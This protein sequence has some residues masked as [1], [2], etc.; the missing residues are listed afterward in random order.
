[1]GSDTPVMFAYALHALPQITDAVSAEYGS[2][3]EETVL[4]RQR[5]ARWRAEL[6]ES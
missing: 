6:L 1:M 4:L 5:F 3:L 2:S